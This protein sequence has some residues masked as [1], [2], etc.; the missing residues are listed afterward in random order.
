MWKEWHLIP[1][2]SIVSVS[3]KAAAVVHVLHILFLMHRLSPLVPFALS[4]CMCVNVGMYV[5]IHQIWRGLRT[6]ASGCLNG[7]DLSSSFASDRPATPESPVCISTPRAIRCKH[8]C[9]HTHAHTRT[10]SVMSIWAV[11]LIALGSAG[12]VELLMERASSVCGRSTRHHPTLNLT[13]W[14][15]PLCPHGC[16][17]AQI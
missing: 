14:G 15:H 8:V 12:S 7:R 13:W 5:N 17:H 6:A 3:L 4:V 10:V 1:S 11:V 2:T 9:A 16:K